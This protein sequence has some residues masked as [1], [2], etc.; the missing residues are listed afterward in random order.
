MSDSTSAN[1]IAVLSLPLLLLVHAQALAQDEDARV[2]EARRVFDQ[3]Q[4]NFDE[5]R[6]VLAARDFQRA[7]ELMTQA[8]RETAPLILYNVALSL[9]E[10]PGRDREARDTYRRFVAQTQSTDPMIVTQLDR[11]RAR[12]RELDARIVDEQGP[13]ASSSISPVGP[14]MMGSA[15]LLL[16]I[17]IGTG[18]AALSEES[19]LAEMCAGDVCS[20]TI[21]LRQR[22]DLMR[23][24]S[25]TTDVLLVAGGAALITGILLTVLLHDERP[26]SVTAMCDGTRCLLLLQ[27]EF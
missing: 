13:G 1:R 11:A 27:G 26:S 10:V 19:A 7:Y 15:G 16:A 24:L 4:A 8:G 12:V 6:F 9:D 18:I 25:I 14:V 17:G 22:V 23:A 20:N 3:A 2:T 5:R 21:D